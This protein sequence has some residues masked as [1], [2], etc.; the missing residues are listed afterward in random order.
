MRYVMQVRFR[1]RLPSVSDNTDVIEDN[2]SGAS[3]M[4]LR[5]HLPETPK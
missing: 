1:D 2:G 4:I 5:S 3:E